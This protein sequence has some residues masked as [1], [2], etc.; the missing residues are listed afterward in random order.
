MLTRRE[1]IRIVPAQLDEFLAAGWLIAG[2]SLFSDRQVGVLV[3]RE[4]EA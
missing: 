3:W 2:A 1:Y 4:V